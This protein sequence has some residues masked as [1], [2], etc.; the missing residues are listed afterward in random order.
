MSASNEWT[1]WHLTPKGWERGTEKEDFRRIDRD[2]PTDR[3]LTAKYREYLS[4][5]FSTMDKS[6][7]VIWKCDDETSIAALL[8]KFGEA[9]RQL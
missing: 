2:P 8:A 5:S 4:S 6:S 7:E 3:V 1:E 9:P